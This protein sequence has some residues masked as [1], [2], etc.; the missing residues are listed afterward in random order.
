MRA[1]GIGDQAAFAP[2]G[3]KRRVGV[4]LVHR[5]D[6]LEKVT[7]GGGQRFAIAAEFAR[8]ARAQQP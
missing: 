4:Y 8:H 3:L 6:D 7:L 5:F 1:L 2:K